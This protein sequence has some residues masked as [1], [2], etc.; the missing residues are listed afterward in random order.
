V[1]GKKVKSP[2]EAEGIGEKER[3]K[4]FRITSK[5]KL[6]WN[7]GQ[8]EIVVVEKGKARQCGLDGMKREAR[9]A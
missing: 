4:R 9:G 5:P 3:G 1:Y 7:Q 6:G 2:W 8:K